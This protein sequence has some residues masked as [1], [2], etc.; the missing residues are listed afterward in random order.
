MSPIQWRFNVSR[1]IRPI[2]EMEEVR[3]RFDED[4]ARPFMQAI[5]DRIPEDMKTWAP[6]IDVFEK[7]GNFVARIELPGMMEEDI[8]VSVAEDILTIKGERKAE[9]G[10]KDEDYYRSEIAYGTFSRSISLPAGVDTR[11]IEAVYADG[12][13]RITLPRVPESKPQKVSIKIKSDE[14]K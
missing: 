11:N 8:D 9:S 5:W 3:R 7:G 12:I 10:L 6:A 4:I 1:P 2:R 14:E 13:L